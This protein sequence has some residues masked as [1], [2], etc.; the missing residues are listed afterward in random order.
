[1]TALP[2]DPRHRYTVD[3]FAALPVDRT[4]RYELQEGAVVVSPRPARLHMNVLGKLFF[5]LTEQLP[6][7]LRAWIEIDIDL[8]LDT[9][10]VRVPDIVV[11]NHPVRYEVPITKAADVVLA[12]EIISPGSVRTDTMV[13]PMEYAD[14]GIPNLWLV[15]PRPPVTA[16]VYRLVGHEYEESSRAEHALVTDHPSPLR[17]DL[18]ALIR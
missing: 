16:T 3:E 14:A 2:Y 15:D 6:A 18:D 5:Q 17:I 12:V 11:T 13:K 1:M 4:A 10:V 8:E 9:P 7:D